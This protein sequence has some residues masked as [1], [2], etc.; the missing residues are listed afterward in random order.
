MTT[1]TVTA[2]DA[3]LTHLEGQA[4]DGSPRPVGREELVPP[5]VGVA[6]LTTGEVRGE[7]FDVDLHPGP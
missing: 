2:G 6:A 4:D 7:I 1:A 3:S 5:R